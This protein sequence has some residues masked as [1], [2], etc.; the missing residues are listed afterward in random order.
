TR[1]EA[2]VLKG[3]S[4]SAS[5][6]AGDPREG[7]EAP[8]HARGAISGPQPSAVTSPPR[9]LL[10]PVKLAPGKWASGRPDSHSVHPRTS[11]PAPTLGWVFSPPPSEASLARARERISD[12]GAPVLCR[13]AFCA[14]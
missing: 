4:A 6:P 7:R 1:S 11:A 13:S 12:R 14:R 8:R 10:L 5:T 9:G 2:R 3:D